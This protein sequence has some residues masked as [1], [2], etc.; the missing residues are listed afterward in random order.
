MAS[1][2]ANVDILNI[3]P[4]SAISAA[5]AKAMTTTKT[6]TKTTKTGD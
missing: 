1:L 4:R 5:V 3:L 6:T 2:F